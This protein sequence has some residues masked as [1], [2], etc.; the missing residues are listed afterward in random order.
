MKSE[1]VDKKIRELETQ[2]KEAKEY[3]DLLRYYSAYEGEDEVISSQERNEE[4]QKEKTAIGFKLFTKIP[5]LDHLMGGF[6][7]GQVI[8]LSGA[9]GQGKTSFAQ[10][11]TQQFA[12][13]NINC[14][15]F[16]YEVGAEEFFNKFPILPVFYL[17]KTLKQNST[18]WLEQRIVESI[19]KYDCEVVFIDHLHYLLE[20]Q[21][22]AE[23]KSIS[24]LIGMMMRELKKISITHNIVIFLISHARKTDFDKEPEIDDLRD[25]SFV[26]QESDAVLFI[27]RMMDK[28]TKR[29]TN[30]AILKVAKNRRS[31]NLGS[32]TLIFANGRF[33]ELE[34]SIKN[35]E[36]EQSFNE[37][38]V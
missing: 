28:N 8:V 15:W 26:G 1:N 13:D 9:T 20:M 37:I 29:T 18:S 11:L 32:M 38:P 14:L 21:K 22:M 4:L 17:P 30:K 10:T 5:T 36:T 7:K 19:A 16:S 3:A 6:R 23:A 24:L 35:Y 2:S 12:E 27:T 25:S 34:E 31:G 33:S